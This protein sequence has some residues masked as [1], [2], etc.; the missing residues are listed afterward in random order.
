MKYDAVHEDTVKD[1]IKLEG[2]AHGCKMNVTVAEFIADGLG[3][4]RLKRAVFT[5]FDLC[6]SHPASLE[7]LTPVLG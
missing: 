6:L 1:I 3:I 4:M 7:I 5:D 2:I